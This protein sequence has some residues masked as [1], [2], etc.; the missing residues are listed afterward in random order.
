MTIQAFEVG[1]DRD[2]FPE[3]RT[4][5][6]MIPRVLLN[7]RELLREEW[8]EWSKIR[9]NADI[10]LEGGVSKIAKKVLTYFID[11]PFSKTGCALHQFTLQTHSL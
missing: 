6:K 3:H 7:Q 5:L 4:N 1:S 10:A 2:M 9:K 11:T 8:E